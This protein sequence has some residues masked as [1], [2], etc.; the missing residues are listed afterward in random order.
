MVFE[1]ALHSPPIAEDHRILKAVKCC[2]ISLEAIKSSFFT[3]F[4]DI[5]DILAYLEKDGDGPRCVPKAVL[6][7]ALILVLTVTLLG[8][9]CHAIVTDPLPFYL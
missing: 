1:A 9:F 8:Y 2:D 7:L 5:R 6:I 3:S 4:A